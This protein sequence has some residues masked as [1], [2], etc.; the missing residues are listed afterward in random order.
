M[1][2]DE[3]TPPDQRRAL[4]PE[5][6]GARVSA[7]LEAAERDARAVIDAAHRAAAA[8]AEELTLESVAAQLDALTARVATLERAIGAGAPAQPP[9]QAQ[10]PDPTEDPSLAAQAQ[11]A[12]AAAVRVRVI[13]LALGGY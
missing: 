2:P 6:V 8:S 9:A 5:E 4:S 1:P 10:Q 12:P 11:A 13:E 7:I 3:S